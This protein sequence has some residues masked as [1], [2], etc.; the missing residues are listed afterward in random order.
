MTIL[1]NQSTKV[2]NIHNTFIDQNILITYGGIAKRYE[3]GEFI[4]QEGSIPNHFFQVIEGAV[5]VYSTN[6]EGKELTHYYVGPGDTFGESQVL[7]GKPYTCIAQAK[8]ATVIIKINKEN[9][10]NI[11]RDFPEIMYDLLFTFA[12]KIYEGTCSAKML[13]GHTPEERIIQFLDKNKDI[14]KGNKEKK[15]VPYT[16][17]Q[18]ADFT[19]LRVETVIR[20]LIKMSDE[21]T[22]DIINRK[23]YY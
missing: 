9:F 12:G 22:V 2:P 4:Y 1:T 6:V 15:I 16:R 18:I 5:R 11:L 8:S 23:V 19:G 14:S 17:Q 21:G 7:T 10:L 13:I 20:T 3:K